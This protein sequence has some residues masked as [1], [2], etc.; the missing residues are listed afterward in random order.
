MLRLWLWAI[1]LVL[2]E[3]PALDSKMV[4]SA[5]L[6]TVRTSGQK[7]VLTR[8]TLLCHPFLGLTCGSLHP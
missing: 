3:G 5:C 4:S 7:I 2:G 8:P 1:L 6:Q